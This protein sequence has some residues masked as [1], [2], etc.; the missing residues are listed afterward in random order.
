[1]QEEIPYG[2]CQCGCG[3]KTRNNK[4][5]VANI[6]LQ[7]H[8]NRLHTRENN[9]AWKGGTT[10]RMGYPAV[11]KTGHPRAGDDGYVFEHVLIAEK[12]LGRYL[13]PSEQVHHADNNKGKTNK[14]DLIIC[15]DAAYHTKIHARLKAQEACGNADWVKCMF[16]HTYD[17]IA[18]MVKKNGRNSYGH[19]GCA[20]AE[21]LKW[22]T[23]KREKKRERAMADLLSHWR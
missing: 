1:M 16:C 10:M 9:P 20:S 7:G 11:L 19:P 12:M 22:N 2:Y 13:T 23:R 17:D 5:G 18:N 8:V 21:Y 3:Q 4:K 6:F 14:Y 15:P